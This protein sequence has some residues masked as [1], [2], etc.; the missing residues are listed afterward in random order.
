M[1]WWILSVIIVGGYLWV[2]RYWSNPVK[3]VYF[4]DELKEGDRIRVTIGFNDEVA[5]VKQNYPLMGVI[6][7]KTQDYGTILCDYNA[8]CFIP[9]TKLE[10]I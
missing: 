2:R 8:N 6:S 1:I 3:E 4:I 7:I 5:I 9:H 10:K